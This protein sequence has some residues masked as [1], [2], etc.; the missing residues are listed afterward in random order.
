LFESVEQRLKP[1]EMSNE[2]EDPENPHHPDE[3]HYLAGFP[4]NLEI[5]QA[6]DQRGDEVGKDSQKVNLK[7][8]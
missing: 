6:L 4:Q 3:S 7:I 8:L 2:F 5:L 1:G